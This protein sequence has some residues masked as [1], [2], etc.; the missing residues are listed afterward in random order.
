MFFCTPQKSAKQLEQKWSSHIAPPLVAR[1]GYV[2]VWCWTNRS[3]RVP[4]LQLYKNGNFDLVITL[5]M[6]YAP[7][8]EAYISKLD[9]APS[10]LGLS[11]YGKRLVVIACVQRNWDVT[12]NL[13]NCKMLGVTVSC[14]LLFQNF[15]AWYISSTYH[16]VTEYQIW[17]PFVKGLVGYNIVIDSKITC[18]P[19]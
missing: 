3:I 1:G 7:N 13:I 15:Q 4:P 9:V 6:L 8:F 14:C 17:L 2:V 5:L 11:C 18:P 10:S 19:P 12:E 16:E